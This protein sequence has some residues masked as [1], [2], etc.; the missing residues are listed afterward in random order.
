MTTL[1]PQPPDAQPAAAPQHGRDLVG[2]VLFARI[3]AR[4]AYDHPE[5]AEQAERIVDQAV[6]FVATCAARGSQGLVPSPLVDIGWH[7]FILSTRD[8]AAFCA[9]VAGRF[10]H[11]VPC[12]PTDAGRPRG[13][14]IATIAAIE[15]AGFVVDRD[16]WPVTAKRQCDPDDCGASGKDGNE[17]RDTR[18]DQDDEED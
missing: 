8:Y 7:T 11:H 9:R 18:T 6:A 10:I 14:Q 5:H 12:D 1:A 2:P 17:N 4:I 13:G 16:L 15:T 3:A